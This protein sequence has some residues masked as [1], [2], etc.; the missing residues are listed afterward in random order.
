[1]QLVK[2]LEIMEGIQKE[3]NGGVMGGKMVFMVDFIV[4]GGC[5]VI[6]EVVK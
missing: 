6:E 1:M 4:F 2:V 3:F 5:V